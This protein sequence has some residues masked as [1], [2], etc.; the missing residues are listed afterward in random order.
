MASNVPIF[1]ADFVFTSEHRYYSRA[2]YSSFISTCTTAAKNSF[3]LNRTLECF[4]RNFPKHAN[5][6]LE[7][8]EYHEATLK[9]LNDV[10]V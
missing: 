4:P 7:N 3:K 5:N 10:H 1:P 8:C 2:L 6:K 9:L